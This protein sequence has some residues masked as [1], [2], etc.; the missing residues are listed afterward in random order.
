MSAVVSEEV[1]FVSV[2]LQ[3][4]RD[5]FPHGFSRLT[6]FLNDDLFPFGIGAPGHSIHRSFGLAASFDLKSALDELEGE[7]LAILALQNQCPMVHEP[8]FYRTFRKVY[9]VYLH[10]IDVSNGTQ[11][12]L[13]LLIHHNAGTVESCPLSLKVTVCGLLISGNSCIL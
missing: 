6:Q 1:I 9:I 11:H 10:G 5:Y 2:K 4:K 7:E 8:T 12:A 3:S 13:R